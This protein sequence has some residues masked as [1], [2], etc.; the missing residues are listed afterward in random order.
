MLKDREARY[1]AVDEVSK[2]WT[3]LSDWTTKT[4]VSSFLGKHKLEYLTPK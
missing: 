1:A 3:Q 4:Q 2:N